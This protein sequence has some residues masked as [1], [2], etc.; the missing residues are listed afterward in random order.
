MSYIKKGNLMKPTMEIRRSILLAADRE[1]VWRAIT[2]PRHFSNWFGCE[3][4]F[5]RLAAGETMTFVAEGATDFGRI[6]TV[7]PPERFAFHWMPE[8]GYLVETL[9]TFY[10]E[11]VAEGT[12][13]T[14]I[15]QGLEAL[16]AEV[17]QSRF[18][19]NDMGWKG[20]LDN[21]AAYLQ[22]VDDV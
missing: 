12:R 4:R 7:E 6:A 14:V 1:K 21:I 5:N 19:L 13:L 2:Q 10:L 9:V 16:P 3:V 20:Q 22:K 11:S 17:R 15:E 18:N 8:P